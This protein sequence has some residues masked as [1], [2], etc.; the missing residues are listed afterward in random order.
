MGYYNYSAVPHATT[1]ECFY[2][3]NDATG[4]DLEQCYLVNLISFY[5][6]NIYQFFNL[7][8]DSFAGCSVLDICGLFFYKTKS[9]IYL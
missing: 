5:L 7:G 1:T 4:P 6:N 8:M 9:Y 3:Y 2:R